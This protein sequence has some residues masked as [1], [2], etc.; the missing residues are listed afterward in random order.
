M[1][2]SKR[3]RDL[4]ALILGLILASGG[5]EATVA[6]EARAREVKAVTLAEVRVA[7]AAATLRLSDGSTL[8]VPTGAIEIKD[9]RRH[10]RAAA[11][12][13]LASLSAGQPLVIKIKHGRDGS[14]QRVKLQLFDSQQAAEAALQTRGSE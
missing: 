11:P 7:S 3:P 8:T 6:R 13:T 5:V 10:Q 2:H 4:T 9:R 14:I 12:A 1:R